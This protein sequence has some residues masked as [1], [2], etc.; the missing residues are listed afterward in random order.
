[1]TSQKS[2]SQFHPITKQSIQKDMQ[3]KDVDELCGVASVAMLLEWCGE[4]RSFM[5]VYSHMKLSGSYVKGIGTYL[6]LTTKTFPE[7]RYLRYVPTWLVRVLLTLG[8]CMAASMR[9]PD[10][11]N[12]I[13]FICGK[14][15]Q[16]ICYYDPNGD[17]KQKHMSYKSWS[18]V[19]NRRSVILKVGD[20]T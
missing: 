11:T 20:H 5:D 17:E 19:S 6:Q 2:H 3:I 1:M 16:G 14:D 9:K 15:Q 8:Y 18:E 7:L 13:I 10:G 12:H 4:D